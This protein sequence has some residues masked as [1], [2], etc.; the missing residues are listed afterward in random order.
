MN[1]SN[2]TQVRF[3]FGSQAVWQLD[4]A[5]RLNIAPAM[6][7]APVAQVRQ[8]IE[9]AFSQPLDFVPLDQSVVPGD[10]IVFA[11]DSLLP[12]LCDVVTESLCWFAHH[13]V[14]ASNMTVVLT[15]TSQALVESLKNRIGDSDCAAASVQVHDP[16]SAECVAY[17]A[18]NDAS[19]P[20]YINR[21][22]V[23]ADVVVPISCATPPGQL[24]N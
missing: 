4:S 21:T 16:D 20:I 7:T 13:G 12:Q 10:R 18:A 15:P 22:V 11:V 14:L 9:T 19:D 6:Q 3:N 5:N 2:A 1:L 24:D 23:D 17:L 8:A